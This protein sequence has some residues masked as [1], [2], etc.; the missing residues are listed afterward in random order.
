MK[1]AICDNENAD[2]L[3]IKKLVLEYSKKNN[4]FFDIY[5]YQD[6]NKLLEE[7]IDFNYIILDV[8]LE[9]LTGIQLAKQ[10]HDI[11]KDIKI[12]FCS[13]NPEYSI[14]AFE[15]NAFRYLV[16]PIDKQKL[17]EYLDEIIA[18]SANDSETLKDATEQKLRL[19][20]NMEAEFSAESM[21]RAKGFSDAA[22]TFHKGSVNVVIATEELSSEEVAQILDIVK[23]ETGEKTENIKIMAGVN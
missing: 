14:E 10:I 2:L 17:F 11:N 3:H 1:L 18:A 4:Y 12:I 22:V 5:T 23:R 9:D 21:I 19:V 16:K 13:I 6:Y 8:L 20:A 15:V 7:I